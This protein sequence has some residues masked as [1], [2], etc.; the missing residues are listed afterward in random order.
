[1]KEP[2]RE[3]LPTPVVSA[4]WK[5][6]SQPLVNLAF[7]LLALQRRP[8]FQ[9]P[10]VRA[11]AWVDLPAAWAASD[12][13][14]PEIMRRSA[15]AGFSRNPLGVSTEDRR[16]LAGLGHHLAP[17]AVLEVGTH[18]GS[19]TLAFA[20]AT[21]TNHDSRHPRRE[22]LGCAAMETLQRQ[23]G[24]SRDRAGSRAR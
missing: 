2:L 15:T 22:R 10:D 18:M 21:D 1:M 24:T 9:I 6:R 7:E 20:E 16:A 14:W 11:R 12:A 3:R 8:T 19:S 17:K 4:L 5:I 13:V 23:P